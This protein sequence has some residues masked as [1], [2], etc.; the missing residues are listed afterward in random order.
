MFHV[1]PEV[2][3]SLCAC[4]AVFHARL[5]D[6][7]VVASYCNNASDR[8]ILQLLHR[9]HMGWAGPQAFNTMA[10]EQQELLFS[11]QEL[12]QLEQAA[13]QQWE[14]YRKQYQALQQQQLQE[15]GVAVDSD[16]CHDQAAGAGSQQQPSKQRQHHAHLQEQVRL[17]FKLAATVLMHNHSKAA[18]GQ[19]AAAAAR[20][21][22]AALN[23]A[24]TEQHGVPTLL[25]VGAYAKCFQ[26]RVAGRLMCAQFCGISMC[27]PVARCIGGI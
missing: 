10:N 12:R 11:E 21:A 19:D 26:E 15:A 23:A 22:S 25:Q 9:W 1:R 4:R 2:V 3:G 13:G 18:V 8:I 24:A 5:L 20:A 14:K 7:L 27:A 16:P 17:R 6:D